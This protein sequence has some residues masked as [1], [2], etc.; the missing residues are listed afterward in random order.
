MA[1]YS[2]LIEEAVRSLY[3]DPNPD[4]DP[5]SDLAELRMK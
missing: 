5:V 4:D 3:P 1:A 2:A